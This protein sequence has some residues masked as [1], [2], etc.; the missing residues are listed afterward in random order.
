[1]A[2]IKG[3]F[4]FTLVTMISLVAFYIFPMD[5]KETFNEANLQANYTKGKV[6][7][8]LSKTL[9]NDEQTTP[10]DIENND[11]V[12]TQDNYTTSVE[13]LNNE[14]NTI[15]D[16]PQDQLENN[17]VENEIAET[18]KEENDEQLGEILN[19][20]NLATETINNS[21]NI[22][23]IKNNINDLLTITN[24][25]SLNLPVDIQTKIN[26]LDTDYHNI[27]IINDCINKIKEFKVNNNLATLNDIRNDIKENNIYNLLND[28]DDLKIKEQYIKEFE[29]FKPIIQDTNNPIVNVESNKTYTH[30]LNLEIT[31]E[32]NF[33]VYINNELTDNLT[34]TENGTYELT[35][36]DEALNE[37]KINF[38][39]QKE[40]I[41]ISLPEP[42]YRMPM[43]NWY[44][45]QNFSGKN[46]H[47]GVDFGSYN[48]KE[49]IYPIADGTV[50]YVGHDNYGANVVKILHN[51][52][53]KQ[54]FST[55][56]HM[57]EVYFKPWQIVSKNDLLGLMGSTGYSTG[58]HL[59]LEI[60]TCDWTYNCTYAKYKDSL[61]NPWDILPNN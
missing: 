15:K 21:Q 54:I 55:Y 11:V 32:T 35:I 19:D 23:E 7:K 9:K 5:K 40:E 26:D 46:G 49:E 61:I 17:I 27:L 56:A 3:V 51:I 38:S 43:N 22:T 20:L 44:I 30:E 12:N 39:I 25:T 31:D 57:R 2:Q 50:I 8:N 59:H 60:T 58:P 28:I 42:T 18:S 33:K 36:I 34:I 29:E 13:Q 16:S 47:K 41:Q 53:G 1:M 6:T 10:N 45:T 14:D 4:Y 48:K 52:Q 24:T 37:T